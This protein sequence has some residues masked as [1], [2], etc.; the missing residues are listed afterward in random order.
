MRE[1]V[2]SRGL[3]ERGWGSHLKP[4]GFSTGAEDE[5][6]RMHRL[7]KALARRWWMQRR[8]QQGIDND[9]QAC[10]DYRGRTAHWQSARAAAR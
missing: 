9:I 2:G 4:I 6:R 1:V 3:E 8:A 7:D 10:V 5:T